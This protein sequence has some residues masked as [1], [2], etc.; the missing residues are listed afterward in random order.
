VAK[1]KTPEESKLHAQLRTQLR[2][3]TEDLASIKA[4]NK[5]LLG[6]QKAVDKNLAR[7][8]SE[9]AALIEENR[10]LAKQRDEAE[11]L[12]KQLTAA[13]ERLAKQLDECRKAQQST[14]ATLKDVSGRVEKLTA[15]RDRLQQQVKSVEQQLKSSGRSPILHAQDV[16]ALI[17]GL[18]EEM[19]ANLGDM[20]LRD[21][22]LR[23][24]VGFAG[25]GKTTG[26]VLP[27]VDGEQEIK[28]SLQ[29]LVIRFDRRPFE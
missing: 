20:K 18:I 29:E 15:E 8:E 17:D 10:L 16:T 14:Q 21:G 9:V 12:Q 3:A 28:G 26:F 19:S 13:A 7:R 27:T 11:K 23:L 22:E 6:R 5:E 1:A 4:E 24:Q 2:K 25:T